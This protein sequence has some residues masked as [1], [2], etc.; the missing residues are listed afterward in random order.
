MTNGGK[1][2]GRRRQPL[3]N[4]TGVR[5]ILARNVRALIESRGATELELAESLRIP[6]TV[7]NR[8]A[9]GTSDVRLASVEQIATAFGLNPWQLLFPGLDPR[10][11]PVMQ[12][13]CDVAASAAEAA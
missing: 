10:R 1:R 13:R 6:Q 3:T 12:P 2:P 5:L 11:L 8:A 4:V 7:L 9:N